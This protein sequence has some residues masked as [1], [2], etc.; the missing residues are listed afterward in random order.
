MTKNFKDIL[1]GSGVILSMTIGG[2]FIGF[3]LRMML[4]R[5]LEV[6]D[7]GLFYAI[8]G[9]LSPISLLKNFGVNRAMTKFL[10]EFQQ[11]GS[12]NRMKEA[13]NWGMLV[14]I[15]TSLMVT[16]PFF[17]LSNWIS[18]GFFHA[19][20]ASEYFR[21][22]LVY[23]VIGTMGG[24]FAA[25]FHGLKRPLLLSF[26]SLFPPLFILSVVFFYAGVNLSELCFVYLSA[27]AIVLF[28]SIFVLLRV[29]PYF[30][31][32]SSLSL[33]G[34]KKLLSF[35]LKAM[36]SPLVN[37]IFGRLDIILL[38][39]FQSLS[40]VGFYSAAQPFSRLFMIFGSS[41]GKMMLP[42]SSEIFASGN[43]S[44]LKKIIHNLQRLTLFL[45]MPIAIV[46]FLFS[47]QLLFILFG[48]SYEA[49]SLVVRLLVIGTLIH[50]LTIINTNVLTG[51]GHPLKVTKMTALSS[52]FNLGG[53]ILLIPFWGMDGAAIS[54][55]FSY[56]V[57]FTASC[58]Y[59][60]S[61]LGQSFDLGLL[62]RIFLSSTVM[63][64]LLLGVKIFI[65][66][67]IW[68]ILLVFFPIASILYLLASLVLGIV[69][70]EEIRRIIMKK[71][72]KVL[73]RNDE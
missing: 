24:V 22:M 29:F 61:L 41:V 4:T 9:F 69:K 48:K 43:K 56:A 31:I 47:A 72:P 13:L 23:L 36:S 20:Q 28:F 26:R 34:F 25:F 57:M 19:P 15:T 32:N 73:I 42:Y 60:K 39:Y 5:R 70:K 51:I 64:L 44:E 62:V 55:L 45:L 10:P 67:N 12:L 30:R 6:E 50:S 14:S 33:S 2:A 17:F 7:F 16:L 38:T 40:Q 27:E 63:I 71:E 66:G 53:N 11:A 49:G 21:I 59:M 3:L 1:K 35:G 37:R 52:T 46:F 68:K 8:I 58:G 18:E 65:T 54:S